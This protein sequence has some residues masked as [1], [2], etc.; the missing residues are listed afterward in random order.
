M[1]SGHFAPRLDC[2]PVTRTCGARAAR[3]AEE[4]RSA[5]PFV[6]GVPRSRS[7]GAAADRICF[8][9]LAACRTLSPFIGNSRP[10]RLALHLAHRSGMVARASSHRGGSCGLCSKDRRHERI[11][12][13]RTRG[14]RTRECWFSGLLQTM[15]CAA[16]RRGPRL[17]GCAADQHVF[18]GLAEKIQSYLRAQCLLG[19]NHPGVEDI[20]RG[21]GFLG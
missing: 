13:R 6:T 5:H 8:L 18:P 17:P 16:S 20:S 11:S 3:G 10:L 15:V 1:P 21:D 9:Q 2:S 7:M 4:A 12:S 14:D 19:G